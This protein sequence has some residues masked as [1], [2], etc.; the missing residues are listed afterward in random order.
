MFNVFIYLFNKTTQF[1]RFFFL[2]ATFSLNQCTYPSI[3][4]S[5][6]SFIHSHKHLPIHLFIYLSVHTSVQCPSIYPCTHR[7][8]S[9]PPYI[10]PSVHT[11]IRPPTHAS[12]HSFYVAPIEVD[13]SD[14]SQASMTKGTPGQ[15]YAR[16]CSDSFYIHV[17][18]ARAVKGFLKCAAYK[19]QTHEYMNHR[20]LIYTTSHLCHSQ[21][22]PHYSIVC[23]QSRK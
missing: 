8:I 1:L 10:H 19:V 15:P 3:H 21:R 9:N 20:Q 18:I 5:V 16:T 13:N 23:S 6:H 11:T 7:R 2:R 12:I 17:F 14:A 4:S 22:R